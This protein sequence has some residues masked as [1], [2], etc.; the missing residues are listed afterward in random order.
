MAMGLDG[1]GEGQPRFHVLGMNRL[2]STAPPHPADPPRFITLGTAIAVVVVVVTTVASSIVE[3]SGEGNVASAWLSVAERGRRKSLAIA[4]VAEGLVGCFVLWVSRGTAGLVVMP[5]ISMMVLYGSTEKACL[6]TLGLTLFL[7][8]AG[9]H[10]G[11]SATTC[12][13]GAAGFIAAAAFVIVFSRIVVKER[14]ARADVERLAAEVREGNERLREYA[15]KVEELATTKERNRV[16]RE[17]HDGLGHYLTVAAVQIEA[18]RAV[19]ETDPSR[20]NQ[21]LVRARV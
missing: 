15:A 11:Y 1:A 4:L 19:L 14:Y 7:V 13:Q 18:A 17:I 10:F 12:A 2:A 3:L 21:C 20:A 9:A 8:F 6:V 5:F 16:A